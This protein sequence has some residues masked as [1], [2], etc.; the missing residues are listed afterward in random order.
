MATPGKIRLLLVF[1]FA[2]LFATA[3]IIQLTYTP[4]INLQKTGKKLQANLRK[5]EDL[6]QNL[7]AD[8][9]AFDSLKVV[10]K[11][12][13]YALKIIKEFTSENAIWLVTARDNRLNFWSGVKIIPDNPAAYKEGYSFVKE[14]NG[15]YEVVK[16]TEGGFSALFFILVKNN[17]S[18]ENQYLQNVFPENLTKDK[19]ITLAGPKDKN[20]YS[21]YS[22]GN[23]YLFSVKAK[24][25]EVN[26]T[27]FY[28]ELAFWLLALLVLC[29]L[30]QNCAVYIANTG[31]VWL[32]IVAL[33]CFIVLFRFINIHF[34]LPNFT[35]K[36]EMFSP[37][38]YGSNYVYPSLGDFCLNILCFVWLCSFTFMQ[39][40]RL[41]KQTP[42]NISGYAIFLLSFA[43]L[44]IIS[45]LLLK[46]FYGLIIDP[47]INF[48][49]NNVLTLSGFSMLGVLMLCFTFLI[50]YLLTEVFLA[51]AFSLNIPLNQKAAIFLAVI[52]IITAATIVRGNF[53][54]IYLLY[55]L[56]VF[57]RAYSY[58]NSKGKL[59]SGA[60]AL[61]LLICAVISSLKLYNFEVIK[62]RENRKT[63]ISKLEVPDDPT[64][65]MLF[66]KVE[67]KIVED[68]TIANY[69]TDSLN[70]GDFIKTRLQKLY[71]NGYLSQ[72]NL[73]IYKF[74]DQ[75][76]PY[77]ADK[78]LSLNIFRDM[79]LYSAF[80]VS[81]YFYR[82]N[83]SFGSRHYFAILPVKSDKGNS[84]TVII[85]LKS[86]P[87][88]AASSF[89]GLLI[90]GNFNQ[91]ENFKNYSYAFYQDD[92]LLSQG[93]KYIYDLVNTNLKGQLKQ[94]V[95]KKTKETGGEWYQKF[96]NYNHLIYKP[97]KRNL[98]VVSQEENP[99]FFR[100]TAVTF[101]FT[102]LLVFGLII[103]FL[104]WIYIK[105]RI[106]L[107]RKKHP[108]WN[109]R[110][111]ISFVLYK[112]RI[113]LSIISTV[114][115]T[116]L[117]AGVITF[118][119]II[120][121]YQGQQDLTIRDKINRVAAAFEAGPLRNSLSN[122][123]EENQVA[124]NDFANTY[125]ADL[126]LYD[127]N[128]NELINTQPK[129]YE[130]GLQARKMNGRAFIYMSKLHRSEFVNDEKIGDL[131][132]EAAYVP[133]L[134]LKNVPEAYLQLP[135]FA[136]ENDYRQRI[137]SLLNI[138]LNV[139]ALVF[140]A[141]GLFGVIIARQITAP[142]NF[143]QRS[144]SK[145]TYGKEN[146][147]IVWKR[148]DEIG[149]L[150][151]EY[152]KMIAELERSALKLAQSERES[153]WRE[154][155]KQVAHEIKN[156]LTPLKLGLQLLDKSWRDKDPRF[157]QKFERFS[158]SFVEQ[159]ESLSNIASEFSAFA[160]M[161]D[162]RLQ[163]ISLFDILN[164]AVIIFKHMDNVRIFYFPPKE[165]FFINA[166]RD[167][168]LRCFN[169][170]LKNAI[171]ASTDERAGIIDI[172]YVIDQKSVL[173]TIKDN[174]KG[175]PE[176]LRERIFEPN[177][178][179]KSSGT[180]LGL[181]FVK[182]SIENAGGKVWFETQVDKG[183]TFFITLPG[184]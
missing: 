163:R 164:Q 82:E 64:A 57:I 47:K 81:K 100:V 166:D 11:H 96:V 103:I 154:M 44:I 139:Y 25:G 45:A 95:V 172:H 161:P 34:G 145:T 180:G 65:D 29:I 129:I 76:Q 80:K 183:T 38:V 141:I 184:I 8:K 121:Q 116:L 31:Y 20:V 169:N 27:F 83:A 21:I 77:S 170:L 134:N 173:I 22:S 182:N 36:L 13:G 86:R 158:K 2:S 41:I 42:G 17:Y 171:E 175:I 97:T 136:N 138:I 133:L 75:R 72:Y 39:R 94:Y 112:T 14:K 149:A 155:A 130:I 67:Q 107:L 108:G 15:F 120:T 32:S 165:P 28:F 84:G 40:R 160:K 73:K 177:F 101:F 9:S 7:I 59:Y 150:V 60:F 159:I 146:E 92:S 148:N 69:V 104:R 142:L 113:Q 58:A 181:A 102:I 123:N 88:E 6:V 33:A 127:L 152:N 90:E 37:E 66:R 168:L 132:Y 174:G 5:K 35:F 131:D 1:I 61:I 24:T 111:N 55:A 74:D 140:I 19:N 167:Q 56:V 18:I 105:C 48:D 50:I 46:L 128:G 99:I 85:D 54:T 71:F 91:D 49:I 153:A 98:I 117:M 135:Y 119:S 114:V 156:P 51:I 3:V 43:A 52:L 89:P 53:S 125:A 23:N 68:P 143:I 147:P 30:V 63:F 106:F 115:I 12:P 122:F 16:K 162:T 62:Q 78:P 179:T 4:G 126:T 26:Y 144:I 157:D 10:S 70:H 151:T 79:V 137:G 109:F 110:S 176:H 87:L 178:T 118:L 93:G 124:F